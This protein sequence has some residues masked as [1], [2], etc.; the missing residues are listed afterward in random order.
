[1][2]LFNTQDMHCQDILKLA[3]AK[4]RTATMIRRETGSVHD[5]NVSR[6]SCVRTA[7]TAEGLKVAATYIYSQNG[8]VL[9]VDK[10]IV[11]VFKK[12]VF[13]AQFSLLN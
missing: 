13:P 7:D 10:K 2:T 3:V 1:M 9:L 11:R 6:L 8:F 4:N 5:L 12:P